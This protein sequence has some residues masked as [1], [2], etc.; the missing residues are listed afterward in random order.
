VAANAESLG[1]HVI[2]AETV[3]ELKRALAEAKNIDRTVVI[4]TFVDR[5]EAVPLY[6]SWW[7][8]PVAEVSGVSSV[9]QAR[10]DYEAGKQTQR[11]FL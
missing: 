7:D 1:A 2:R 8:V 11:R 5:Y 3:G 4:Y 9:Q 6:D 10:Q